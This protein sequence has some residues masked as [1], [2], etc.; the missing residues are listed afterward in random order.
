MS[1]L[2]RILVLKRAKDDYP[3]FVENVFSYSSDILTRGQWTGGAFITDITTWLSKNPRTMRVSAKDHF[4]SM[5]FYSHIMWKILRLYF[6][7]MNRE[8]QYFSYKQVMAAYHVGKIKTAVACNP[9]FNGVVDLKTTAEGAISY[10]WDG[11]KKLTV[12][13][14]GLLEFKRGI[15]CPDVYVDDPFQ[16]PDNKMIPTKIN[17]INDVMKNQI[18]DMAQE[19]LH[20]VG[21]AQ[22]NHDFFFDKDLTSRFSVRVLPAIVDEKNKKVLW[23]EWMSWDDLMQRKRERGEKIFNQEYLC[24]PVYSE[25]MFVDTKERLYGVVNTLLKN[26]SLIDWGKEVK[27][28]EEADEE[29][30]FDRVAGWDLGKKNHPAHFV[31]FEKRDNKRVQIHDKWFDRQ[32]YTAQLEH[33]NHFREEMGIYKIYYDAT[34]GELEMMEETGDLPGEFE[35]IH[36]THKSKYKMAGAFDRAITNKQVELLNIP[37]TINQIMMV[38]NELQA[39]ETPEGHGDSFWSVCLS[40]M[41]MEDEGTDI[42]FI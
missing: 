41:D 12:T 2:E 28:R 26:F 11:E 23:E 17:K 16:D 14:K 10:S 20:V 40:F 1:H 29:T 32:D 9:F 13:A 25:N 35:G 30:D 36:F 8:I 4:K 7:G 6:T 22:T 34:R 37:R 19:E 5:S 39:P 31:V 21:T 15:H 18:I 3:Y 24:S 27:R 33:I 38:N 42:S